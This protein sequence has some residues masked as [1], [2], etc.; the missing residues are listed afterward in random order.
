MANEFIARNGLIAQNNTTITGSLTV[1]GTITGSISN[2]ISASYATTAGNGGVTKII[3][4]SGITLSPSSGLGDVQINSSAAAYNT[5]TGSYGS[6]YDT[7]S[8]LATSATNIYSMSLSTTDISNGVYVSGSNNSQINF[9]NAGTYN[10]QFSAQFSNTDNSNQD[11]VV[12]ARKNGTNIPDSSGTVGVPPF[13]AGSNGQALASWNYYLNLSAN[14]YI[15]LCWHTE[16]ANVITLETI[17]AGTSPVHPRT[18]SLILTAQRVDTFLSNTGSFTGTFTGDITGSSAIFSGTITAQKLI[19]QTVTSSIL[20]SSGSNIFGSQLTDVQSFT[21]SLR[22]TGSGNHYVMGGNVGIG[23]TS[24]VGNIKLAVNGQIGGPTFSGT[25]LDVTGGTPELRG[26]S[27]IGYYSSAGN[28]IFYGGSSVEYMRL[29][30]A[31]L[32]GIGTTTPNAKLDVNGNTI[33]TGSLTVTGSVVITGSVVANTTALSI[34]SNTASLNLNNSNF[35]T[36]QLVSGSN[37]YI[38]PSNIKSGQTINILVSTTGS[39]TVSFPSSVK[40]TSGS[41]Y[42][43][44][45]TTGTDIVTMISFDTASL[46]LANVKNLT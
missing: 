8:V 29:T 45:T 41:L 39:A 18:P 36:L 34:S 33:I 32:L 16:Q 10:I 38:N 21:G 12:W 1:T 2:A 43:P 26:N 42:V 28:H 9:T 25:Y 44:T 22:V 20:Y 46:Y 19:V 15:Q 30:T 37:T 31:G 35:F 6:F 7:G 3:A 27:G 4:G 13:K 5:A 14:D 11:V 40:Q 24:F 17:A 23:T